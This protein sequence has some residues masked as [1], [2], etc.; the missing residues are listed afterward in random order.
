MVAVLVRCSL[1]CTYRHKRILYFVAVGLDWHTLNSPSYPM[2]ELSLQR[3]LSKPWKTPEVKLTAETSLPRLF[4]AGKDNLAHK[5]LPQDG[6][7]GWKRKVEK[8][9]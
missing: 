2:S 6:V 9:Y 8:I 5:M 1:S 7:D 3:P 4:H